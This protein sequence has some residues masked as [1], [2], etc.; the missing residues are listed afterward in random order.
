MKSAK[1]LCSLICLLLLAT[2][3]WSMSHWNEQRGVY[4]DLCYL[5]QAHL[6]QRFGMSGFDTDISRDDDGYFAT[7][8]KAIG[9]AGPGL[10]PCHTP[11]PATARLVIQY[12]PGTGLLLALF[13]QGHQVV[14]LFVSA[15]VI[16]FGFALA[17]IFL[18]RST[19]AIVSATVLGLLAIYIM[20]NPSKASYSMAPTM[21]ACALAG[22]LTARL[23][24]DGPRRERIWLAAALGLVLG[25]SVNFRLPNL[26]LSSGYFLFFLL[27]FASSRKLDIA[28]RGLCFGVAFVAGMAPTLLANAINAGSPLSTTYGGADAVPPEFSLGIIW[29]YVTDM[30]FVLLLLAAVSIAYVLAGRSEPGVRRVALVTTANLVVNLAF[31]LSHPL[32]TPYYTLP[33]AMLSLWSISFALL[34]RPMEPIEEK[35][36]ALTTD[37][38][39]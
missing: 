28:V 2:Q 19:P 33:I 4:D 11:M 24:A 1:I 7:K 36:A 35:P 39:S 26:F 16:I 34:L 22:F 37:V 23:F 38:G 18:A 14:P 17:G 27:A 25:L 31:F 12:P 30:Q 13:P 6:F 10:P 5:R 9:F 20:V 15:T 8:L 32:V 3:V 21:A 29:Q